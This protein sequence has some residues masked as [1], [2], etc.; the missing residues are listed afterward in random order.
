MLTKITNKDIMGLGKLEIICQSN[1]ESKMDYTAKKRKGTVNSTEPKTW[2]VKQIAEALIEKQKG[3]TKIEVPMFQR[4]LVWSAQ[5]KK[6]FIDSLKK[7]YP[8]GT[9]LFYELPGEKTYSLIDGLQRS[10]TIK[11]FVSEPTKFFMTQDLDDSTIKKLYDLF[12]LTSDYDSFSEE[13]SKEIQE[14][15]TECDWS[16]KLNLHVNLATKLLEKYIPQ[17]Y[18]KLIQLI[19]IVQPCIQDFIDLYDAITDII[20]PVLVF[21]GDESELPTVFERINNSGTQLGKY[22]IYAATWAVNNYTVQVENNKIIEKITDKYDAFVE[23]GYVLQEYDKSEIERTKTVSVF[24]YALGFGKYICEKYTNLFFDDDKVQDINQVG[25][26][27]LNAC[28]G[29]KNSDI[30]S[31]D[32]LLNSVDINQL[33]RCVIEAIEKVDSILRPYITFKGNARKKDTRVIYHPQNQIISMIACVFREMYGTNDAS[34][35]V[36]LFRKNASWKSTE[37]SLIENLPQHYIYDI[38]AKYWSNGGNGK[39]YKLLN[40]NKYIKPIER[41][42]W[43]SR[44]DEWF[45]LSLTRNEKTSVKSAKL[46]EKLFLN[47]IYVNIFSVYDQTSDT[48]KFDI[49]HLAPKEQIK[50]I[51]AKHKWDGLPISSVGNICYLPEYDNRK[52]QDNTIYQDT[53]Y[54]KAI[55]DKGYTVKEIEDKYTFTTSKDLDWLNRNYMD[56]DYDSFRD[57]YIGF[58]KKHFSRLKEKFYK[59]LNI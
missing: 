20:V 29:Q 56:E 23:K 55:Q 4:N 36:N 39:I 28:F 48:K 35:R 32:K 13:V 8:I 40:N 51:I 24:E 38:L 46:E 10:S 21:S 3:N 6:D 2:S 30:K 27:I 34:Q 1:E 15:M 42:L 52:K 44:L 18:D 7:G 33:E 5:Q 14:Y 53:R 11:E 17:G 59:Q 37:P 57:N 49:E 50:K 12:G 41:E 9:L 54:L 45:S 31:L 19:S 25:F 22:Q 43:D 47:Y 26:E 16:N 58:L